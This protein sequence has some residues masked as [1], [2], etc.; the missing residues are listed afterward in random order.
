MGLY[1]LIYQSQ[2]LVPFETPEL[3]DLMHQAR[4]FNRTHHITGLLLYTPDG[5]FLQVLEGEEEVVRDL[6]YN[7]IVFDPRHYNCQVLAD[8]PCMRRSFADWT[9][10]FRVAQARD[11]RKLLSPVPPDIPGLLVPR[12]HTRPEL[13]EL[14]LDFVANC[15]TEPW[16]EHPV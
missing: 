11:L 3:M 10:G 9:M 12:P 15:E 6:Y 14:L 4:A 8:G 7:H 16:R 2:S 1:Q 5:R 13:L